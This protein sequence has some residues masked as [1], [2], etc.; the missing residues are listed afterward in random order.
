MTPFLD[1]VPIEGN[2]RGSEGEGKI[3]VR[4]SEKVIRNHIINHLP[5]IFII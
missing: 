5:K 3:K 1:C 4:M 2:Y